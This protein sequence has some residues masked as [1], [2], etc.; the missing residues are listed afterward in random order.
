MIRKANIHDVKAIHGLLV[1][2][3]QRGELLSRPLSEIYDHLRDFWVY[4]EDGHEGIGACCALQFCWE[5]LAEIRSLA[6][7]PGFEGRGIGTRLAE[8]ALEEAVSYRIKRVFTL[9]YRPDFF[10]R[11]GF[12][13]IDRSE[14]PI[15]IWGGCLHCV[16]FPDC[17]EIAMI[18]LIDQE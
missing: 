18:K 10:K 8:I 14:L 16:K 1:E 15:K 3:G 9:T 13:V 7:T 2:Y 4:V 17:D 5:E 6:V 11:F 12:N